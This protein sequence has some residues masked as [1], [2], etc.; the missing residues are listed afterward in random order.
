MKIN[1]LKKNRCTIYAAHLHNL[2]TFPAQ[3]VQIFALF[4]MKIQTKAF[5]F[6]ALSTRKL[7]FTCTNCTTIT[8]I[9]SDNQPSSS[10]TI[11]SITCT[12]CTDKIH[13]SLIIIKLKYAQIIHL[14]KRLKINNLGFN[15]LFQLSLTI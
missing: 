9:F 3:F 4:F 6:N 12:I 13:N 5:T 7:F 1:I 14:H 10:C 2:I 8:P 15:K 11:S